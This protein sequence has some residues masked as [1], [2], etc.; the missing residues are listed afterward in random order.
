MPLLRLSNISIAF[1]THALLKDA[2]FQLDPGERVGLLGRNGEGKSTLMK[3]TAG[4]I[5]PDNGE[6]WR[7]PEL[8]LAWLEQSPDLPEDA[9]IYDAVAGGLGEFF[10][11]NFAPTLVCA[12]NGVDA[13]GLCR[14]RACVHTGGQQADGSFPKEIHDASLKK[15]KTVRWGPNSAIALRARLPA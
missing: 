8:R 13:A 10:G 1:G 5:L 2:N 15:I 11:G 9:T 14:R 7:Q 4:N 6:I 3:I 12:A